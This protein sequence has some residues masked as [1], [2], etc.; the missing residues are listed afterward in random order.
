MVSGGVSRGAIQM[1]DE[2][3]LAVPPVGGYQLRII[4]PTV[5]ELT[6]ITSKEPD[7]APVK[8]WDFVQD[9]RVKLPDAKEF[10]VR[11]DAESI[12]VKKAG[13][14]RRVAYAP[15]WPRDLRI[16][17][18]LYLELGRPLPENR[19]VTVKNPGGKLWAAEMQFS[20]RSDPNRWS[21]VIHVNQVGY[22]PAQSKKAMLGYF[23]GSFGELELKGLLGTRDE[24]VVGQPAGFKLLDGSGQVVFQGKLSL[25]PDN[26]FNMPGYQQVL[27]AD[28]SGLKT[29][30][31]YRL[32]VPGLG[33]SYPFV[34]DDGIGA[35]FARA[36]A[37]GIYHQR[38]GT[39]NVMPYT[40][41]THDPCHTAPGSSAVA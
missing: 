1:N 21:P 26:G 33:V 37:L 13:F 39:N 15:L 17:N 31:E 41:F 27:E 35:A 7:P 36:Y 28:F 19:L 23:L 22:L 20:A 6:L 24:N 34:V 32:A 18:Y 25:R 30:G 12:A 8:A 38:C 10:E 11:A 5:L 2:N 3:P 16:G 9:G 40:R 4:S 29:P 14:K